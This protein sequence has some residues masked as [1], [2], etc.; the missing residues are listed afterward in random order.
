MAVVNELRS[1]TAPELSQ[2]VI[3]WRQELR[4]LRLKAA[5]GNVEQPHRI[6]QLRRNIARALT[7]QHQQPT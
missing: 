6:R 1:L 3:Q 5:Q 7:V 2:R 4:D